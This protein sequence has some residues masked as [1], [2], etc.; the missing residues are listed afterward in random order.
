[1]KPFDFTIY[2]LVSGSAAPAPASLDIGGTDDLNL[3]DF[4]PK[5]RLGGGAVTFR[6]S[7]DTSSLLM[8]VPPKS[9]ELVLRLSGGRPPGVTLA[10]VTIS[11][12]GVEIGQGEP[13]NSFGDHVFPIPPAIAA[14]ASA[15]DTANI[16]IRSS[17][18]IPQ[19]VMGGSDTRALGVMVDQAEIR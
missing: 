5:E 13:T 11:V 1:M 8:R 6:W 14:T 7:Q 19:T 4:Y 18:W 15:G 12:N 17:T 2:R 3:V 10:R 9:R 16:E